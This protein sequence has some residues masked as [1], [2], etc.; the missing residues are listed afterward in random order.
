[1]NHRPQAAVWGRIVDAR[2]SRFPAAVGG[3]MLLA[4]GSVEAGQPSS[5]NVV[6][7]QHS[8]LTHPL[9][10]ARERVESERAERE[11]ARQKRRIVIGRLKREIA[12]FFDVVIFFAALGILLVE[13]EQPS[14]QPASGDAVDAIVNDILK[15]KH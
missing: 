10:R 5:A 11:L 2:V 1:M 12:V 6:G 14:H 8:P 3:S 4:V 7:R 15:D 9:R 13:F